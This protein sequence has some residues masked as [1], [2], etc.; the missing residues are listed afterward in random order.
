MYG[1]NTKIGLLKKSMGISL[2]I[3]SAAA[4][5]GGGSAGAGLTPKQELGKI[6]YFDTNL[7]MNRNQACASC[8]LP[9]TFADPA[10]AADPAQAPVSLGSDT[11]L[12]GGRNAPTASYAAFSPKFRYDP[13][14]GLFIGGQ[15]W[16]GRASTL[17]DQ[18]KGPFLNP[19]EMAM[20]NQQ[21]VLNRVADD[22]GPHYLQYKYLWKVVYDVKLSDL[23]GDASKVL[24]PGSKPAIIVDGYY[25]MLADA[26]A[27]FEKSSFFS[28]F[29]SKYDY[30]LAGLARLSAEE[31]HGM[32]LYNGKA[33]CNACHTSDNL[34]APDGSLLP[35]LFTDFTYDNIGVPHNTN[36]LI[37]ANPADLGLGGRADIA[38]LDP[39]GGQNGKFKVS[40]LRNIAVTAPYG[41]N[42]FFATLED[43]VH[44]YNTRDVKKEKWPSPEVKENVNTSE[45]G[46]LGLSPQE[47]ADL[48][49][50]LKTL[51]DGYGAP[52]P[53]YQYSPLP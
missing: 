8:H 41:H 5:A 17:T 19:V 35:P 2:L 27:E 15:F 13:V 30:W 21:A 53:Q 3:A 32:D 34:V 23:E 16:D 38:A 48:V 52:L 11:S 37:D 14:D 25:H 29:T 31:Q 45:L 26:I 40:T 28:P 33:G 6:L 24:L 22:Q 10:N 51:T 1:I 50:F 20:P 9:P 46:R 44:F 42:G 47:E 36:P 39:T 49:A 12:N 7:S 18:A 43:I 4:S